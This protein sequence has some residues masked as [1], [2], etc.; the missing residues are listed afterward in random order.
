MVISM[1]LSW[2]GRFGRQNQFV[3][4]AEFTQSGQH[5]QIHSNHSVRVVSAG[6]ML[7]WR[8]HYDTVAIVVIVWAG[9][10]VPLPVLQSRPQ[11]QTRQSPADAV[12]SAPLNL[13][14]GFVEHP[15]QCLLREEEQMP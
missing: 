5:P 11:T 12:G 6:T 14:P 7:I 15:E 2:L 9:D 10:I 8:K 3:V 4:E 13:P 1:A